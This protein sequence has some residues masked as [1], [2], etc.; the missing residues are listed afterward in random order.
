MPQGSQPLA[1]FR[2]FPT[3][4]GCL[5]PP[6]GRQEPSADSLERTVRTLSQAPSLAMGLLWYSPRAPCQHS[7]SIYRNLATMLRALVYW[8]VTTPFDS[9]PVSLL[10]LQGFPQLFCHVRFAPFV[11]VFP[12]FPFLFFDSLLFTSPACVTFHLCCAR[13]TQLFVFF[14]ASLYPPPT[15]FP[16]FPDPTVRVLQ[17]SRNATEAFTFKIQSVEKGRAP[18]PLRMAGG[19]ARYV[20]Y[21]VFAVF[22][23]RHAVA[24]E[25]QQARARLARLA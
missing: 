10:L 25:P 18:S 5:H 23:R 7:T 13:L 19:N 17:S 4:S 6:V 1:I 12:V 3:I 14:P 16:P 11:P 22:V 2:Q 9:A 21:I 20:R 24:A 8:A 15:P